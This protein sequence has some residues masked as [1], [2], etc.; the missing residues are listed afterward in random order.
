MT[1][2]PLRWGTLLGLPDPILTLAI[3]ALTLAHPPALC[4]LLKFTQSYF[5]GPCPTLLCVCA[6]LSSWRY[7]SVPALAT[8]ISDYEWEAA[9]PK[10][11]LPGRA[12]RSGHRGLSLYQHSPD[13]ALAGLITGLCHILPHSL[14]GPSW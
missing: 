7:T 2:S 4:P 11:E 13:T 14:L 9:R 10:A 8:P 1:G 5:S 3:A 12:L 6:H